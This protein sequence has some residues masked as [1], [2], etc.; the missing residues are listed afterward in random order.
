MLSLNNPQRLNAISVALLSDLRREIAAVK[1]EA[2]AERALWE[3]GVEGA[4]IGAGTRVLIVASE[5]DECFCAGADLKERRGM[6]GDEYVDI[7]PVLFPTLLSHDPISPT[8]TQTQ[9]QP[10]N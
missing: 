1:D 4:R 3:R 5:V 9:T 2:A 6:T 10:T 8:Q 7:S